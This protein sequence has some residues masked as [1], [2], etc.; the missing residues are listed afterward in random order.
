MDDKTNGWFIGKAIDE[1]WDFKVEGIW[2]V[3]EA[4]KQVWWDNGQVILK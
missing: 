4:E 3:D 1:I 2:Q